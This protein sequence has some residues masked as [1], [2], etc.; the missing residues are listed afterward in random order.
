MLELLP[1]FG[2][3]CTLWGIMNLPSSTGMKY[4]QR[5]LHQQLAQAQHVV[6]DLQHEV[7]YLNN[8]LHPILDREE[9]G[10]DMLEDDGW[11]EEEVEPEGDD[12]ICD[13]DSN[14]IEDQ[15]CLVTSGNARCILAIYVMD[16]QFKFGICDWTIM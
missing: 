8:Q 4:T 9:D 5:D 10:P 2:E 1:C 3:S 6:V 15:K 16:L 12:P 11:D 14:H 7:H 13:L